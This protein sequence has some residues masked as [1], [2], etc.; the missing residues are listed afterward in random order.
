MQ[1]PRLYTNAVF[2]GYRRGQRNIYP[3]VAILHIDGVNMKEDTA[4]YL[5]KRCAYIYKVAVK[6]GSKKPAVRAIY[7]TVVAAHG[8]AG[9]VR[10]RFAHNLPPK[11]I[12][13]N[14]KVF[15]Y[16]SNI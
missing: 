4:F 3:N 5:G 14:V 9:A 7:G 2:A 13:E 11:A 15:L 10:A 8:C 16:P 1:V 6:K 12:G